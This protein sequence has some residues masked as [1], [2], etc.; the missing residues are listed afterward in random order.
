M[1]TT[2]IGDVTTGY[3]TVPPRGNG[4]ITPPS[5]E[6]W[7]ITSVAFL[8]LN[9]TGLLYNVGNYTVAVI[10]TSD[11]GSYNYWN[12]LTL[13]CNNTNSLYIYNNDSRRSITVQYNGVVVGI[14]NTTGDQMVGDIELVNNGSTLDI[15]PPSGETWMILNIFGNVHFNVSWQPSGVSAFDGNKWQG[16][17]NTKLRIDSTNYLRI[18]NTDSSSEQMGYVGIKLKTA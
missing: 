6:T 14:N 12:D 17:M 10:Y 15:H 18:T 13:P 3:V 8:A 16:L 4:F 2:K 7:M 9:S 5:G 1:M 11:D